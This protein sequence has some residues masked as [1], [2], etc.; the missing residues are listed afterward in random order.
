MFVSFCDIKSLHTGHF[1]QPSL[2]LSVVFKAMGMPAQTNECYTQL[3]QQ[4]AQEPIM[5]AK[6]F[7]IIVIR[8]WVLK[9]IKEKELILFTLGCKPHH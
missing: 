4:L 6:T 3:L 7:I 8:M 2:T 1:K 9:G 5:Q